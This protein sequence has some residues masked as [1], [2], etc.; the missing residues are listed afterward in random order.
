MTGRPPTIMPTCWASPSVST[1][2]MRIISSRCVS[3]SATP[4]TRWGRTQA[5]KDM[6]TWDEA[7]F[8]QGADIFIGRAQFAPVLFIFYSCSVSILRTPFFE[9]RFKC[10]KI[11]TLF[12]YNLCFQLC[13]EKLLARQHNYVFKES[14]GKS[15]FEKPI[16]LITISHPDNV[17][18]RK[19]VIIDGDEIENK[20]IK[21]VFIMARVHPG[22]TPASFVVQ[23]FV[24]IFYQNLLLHFFFLRGPFGLPYLLPRHRCEGRETFV[25]RSYAIILTPDLWLIKSWAAFYT[26]HLDSSD[27]DTACV[28]GVWPF[29]TFIN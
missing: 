17:N 28:S 11:F 4:D 15:V 26:D 2:R 7:K 18:L 5:Y 1:R 27:S 8:T 23:V 9:E 22:E 19:D 12:D 6:D 21:V 14:L 25:L 20:K 3:P 24:N 10:S 13:L 16:D 29:C